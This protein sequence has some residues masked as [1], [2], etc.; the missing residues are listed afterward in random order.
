MPDRSPIVLIAARDE[1]DRLPATLTALRA[2]LPGA[3]VVVADDGS[4]DATAAVARAGGA[5]V[6]RSE[7]PLGKGGAATLAARAVL[8]ATT[9]PDPPLVLL[10]DADLG[11]SAGE[12]TVLLDAVELGNGDLAV[13]VFARRVGGGF[14]LAVTG[15]RRAIHDQTGLV[16]DAPL[17]GQRAMR[18]EVLACVTPFAP[19]FG[20]EVG[21]TIDAVRAGF[22]VVEVP[23]ELEHRATGRTL[24]GFAHR[25]RQLIDLAAA[26]RA[27]RS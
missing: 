11:A 7:R 5:E 12:L 15:A 13:A 24:R 19:R 22:R 25:G 18:G 10:C 17:S 26:W 21:M 27:R 16:L 4:T 14:G 20:M 3:R 9:A 2:A 6:V 8:D 1:A 23:V